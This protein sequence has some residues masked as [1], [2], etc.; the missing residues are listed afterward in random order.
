MNTSKVKLLG[1]LLIVIIAPYLIMLSDSHVESSQSI[2]PFKMLTGFPC[3]GCGITK[4]IIFL[5]KG[6][7]MQS[8]S[9]HIFGPPVILFCIAAICVLTFELITRKNY[10]DKVIYNRNLGY[11]LAFIL[12]TYHI[13]RLVIFVSHNS[14]SDILKES[15]W[16]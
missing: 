12:G 7:I 14:V 8:L 6:D 11:T 5:Y 10:F 13:T 3:P 2:C 9:Y 1:F 16:K 4:S 15:I